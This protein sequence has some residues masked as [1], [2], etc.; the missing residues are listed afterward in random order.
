MP[1]SPLKLP[2][3]WLAEPWS[4]LQSRRRQN[5]LPHAL[6]LT[7]PRG[8]G[9]AHFAEHLAQSLV[10]SEVALEGRPCGHCQACHLAAKV[11]HPDIH[12]LRPAEPG[13][14]IKIAAVRDLIE[15]A[16]LTTQTAGSRVFLIDPADAMTRGAANA[17]LKTLEEPSSSCV[18]V[19]LSNTPHLLPATIRSRCQQ[20]VFHP[21]P[22]SQASVWLQ[23]QGVK[24]PELYAALAC[25]S[26]AP[27]RALVAAQEDWPAR[28]SSLLRDLQGLSQRRNNP[29]EVASAWQKISPESLFDDLAR[30]FSDLLRTLY[31]QPAKQLFL[32]ALEAPLQRLA[33]DISAQDIYTFADKVNRVRTQALYNLNPQMVLEGLV[34]DWLELTRRG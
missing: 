25:A 7:G 12:W 19:L 28:C 10:C 16:T 22:S 26:G 13:K 32:P 5:A 21:V 11:H 1:E 30:L 14:A 24:D 3:P 20:L 6:L 8:V 34:I 31:G 15:R 2:L 23:E 33:N 9:K 17:L 27:L 29:M 18:L 4:Q